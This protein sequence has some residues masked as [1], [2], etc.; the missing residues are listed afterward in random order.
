ADKLNW[1]QTDSTREGL[2][3]VSARY[4]DFPADRLNMI[5]VTGTNGKTTI[6]YLVEALLK[7]KGEKVGLIGTICNKIGEEIL[8]VTNT[9]PLPLELQQLLAM[10]LE[11]G[12]SYCVMEVSSHALDLGRVAG[13]EF[14]LGVFTNLT[15][16]HLDF[17]VTM[18][19]YRAAKS[20][21]FSGLNT[22]GRKARTK[23]GIINVD[24][25]SGPYMVE[26]C[27][28]SVYTYGMGQSAAVRAEDVLVTATGVA[29]TAIT[30]AGIARFQLKLTGLF[31]VYNSLAAICVG[32]AEN[33]ELSLIKQ[34]LESVPGV[35]GRF[36]TVNE[37][38]AFG[39]IVDY[40][41]TPDSLEN[42][43]NTA[44]EL[45]RGKLIS[46]FGCGGDRDKT[47][48]PIMGAIAAK[49]SDFTVITSDNPR[50]EDPE[51]I[52]KDVEAGVG[53]IA[54]RDKYVKIADRKEAIGQAI[55][56]AGPGDLVL[57]AGKGHETYQIIGSR[58]QPFDDREVAR[59]WL[60]EL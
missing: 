18:D 32:L 51:A 22:Q 2:A 16:D 29:F 13:I 19:N 47:K 58:T 33:M 36:E 44:R 1:V 50:S 37:G 11:K 56:M 28:G 20:K 17:H 15:Q 14:D 34:V 24:D 6:T 12:A 7:A 9:T 10:F 42:V 48:R 8:P 40:A 4:Y 53:Q 5:G 25:P 21:L 23:Y 26:K 57:I 39:V 55:K 49:L 30:P 3:L 31:N 27:Q 46:V 60:R 43:L 35:A 54:S 45:V 59:Q 52:L 38:Q 41:H